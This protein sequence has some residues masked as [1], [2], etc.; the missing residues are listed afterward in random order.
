[1][2]LGLE[3]VPSGS[4]DIDPAVSVPPTMGSPLIGAKTPCPL[5]YIVLPAGLTSKSPLSKR[6]VSILVRV[7]R[8]TSKYLNGNG[9]RLL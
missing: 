7:Y 2:I 4:P 1:M 3:F 6:R 9:P 8:A 5:S